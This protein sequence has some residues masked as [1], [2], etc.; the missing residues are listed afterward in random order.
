MDIMVKGVGE[1]SY[2]PDLVVLRLTFKQ[3]TETYDG[4]M[5]KGLFSVQRFVDEVL[6]L[7]G[8]AVEDLKSQHLSVSEDRHYDESTRTYVKDG[9]VFQQEAKLEFDYN[10]EK[11]AVMME[12]IAKMIDAPLGQVT[13]EIKDKKKAQEETYTLAYRDAENQARIIAKAA[14][15]TLKY[16]KLV[17]TEWERHDYASSGRF[18]AKMMSDEMMDTGMAEM[19]VNTFT[20]ED[21]TLSQTLA[22]H[23][24]AE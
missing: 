12:T 23:W 2:L 19:M 14:S 8:F 15:K 9:F 20:P 4:A 17:D 22:C 7:N 1:K 21:V 11:L 13:F 5:E 3:K 16:C 18:M 24:I 6:K 10:K